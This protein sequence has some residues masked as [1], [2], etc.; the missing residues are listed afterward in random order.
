MNV[1]CLEEPAFFELVEQVVARIKD[2]LKVVED[3]W[4][5]PE[6]AMRLLNVKS[7]STMQEL[8]DEG[9]IAYTQPKP[10]IILYSRSSINHYLNRH[11]K[12]A[13]YYE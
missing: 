9:K 10:K 7:K 4:V 13:F 2:K 3:E 11:K 5:I 1:I 8:R 12:S 6:E